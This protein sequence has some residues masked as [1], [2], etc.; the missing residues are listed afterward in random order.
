MVLSG[1]VIE[2]LNPS[3]WIPSTASIPPFN[4][5]TLLTTM[6]PKVSLEFSF[7][8]SIFFSKSLL[9]DLTW[10]KVP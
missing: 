7:L 6:S 9:T 1:S 4:V 5:P 3:V 10:P 8:V 2:A